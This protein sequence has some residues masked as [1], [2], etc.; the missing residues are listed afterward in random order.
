MAASR[1]NANRN[2]HVA[3]LMLYRSKVRIIRRHD[4]YPNPPYPQETT[5]QPPAALAGLGP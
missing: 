1:V 5:R 2:T 3:G 4:S